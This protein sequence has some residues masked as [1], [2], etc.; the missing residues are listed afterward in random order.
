[1][2]SV[3]VKTLSKGL[4]I[5]LLAALVYIPGIGSVRLFDWDEINFAESAREMLVTGDWF[6]VQINFQSFWEKPPL[7]IWMQALSMK[8][9]GVGEFAARFPNAL[10]GILTL[11][12][13]FAIGSKLRD[14]RF[15]ILW[16]I[17]YGCS[18]LPAFYF[19]SG[20]IDP[21]FNLFI[22]SGI[23]FFFR[24]TEEPSAKWSAL[25]AAAIGLGI[26]TKG[27]VAFL[28][29]ALT[30]FFRLCFRK[31][32]FNFRWKDVFIFLAVMCFVGGFWFIALAFSG[33]GEVIRDFIDYQIRLFETKDA[34]HGG[35]LLYHFVWLFFGCIPASIMALPSF[36]PKTVKEE[37]D[38]HMAEM[39][40]WMMTAFWVVLILFTIVKTKIVHYS[41]FCYFPLSFLA[42][43][44]A[45]RIVSHKAEWHKWQSGL[46]IGIS[47][48][49]GI[50]L[51]VLTL[52]DALKGKLIPLIQDEF[53]VRCLEA[54]SDWIGFE[55]LIG[56]ALLIC[57]IWF[58]L[59]F[60]RYRHPLNF[61]FLAGGNLFFLFVSTVCAVGQVEKYTQ[62]SAVDF[63]IKHKGED[64]YILPTYYKS[65]A[66]YFYS[67]RQPEN[68][69]DDFDFL[70]T[71][72]LDK[73]CYFV[74]KMYDKDLEKFQ[75]DVPDARLIETKS[76]FAFYVREAA[77]Y[78]QDDA[79]DE[80]NQ[81]KIEK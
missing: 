74:V 21:W 75:S 49:F 8:I 19:K 28:I 38:P 79:C 6:N 81:E 16:A 39:F 40:K 70:R 4:I 34:G 13:L 24:Y 29:F 35:F 66:Q 80:C 23:Y 65:Y 56:V 15:G 76:G 60:R 31:F 48:I 72:E 63:F 69:C 55:P 25:S 67:D 26:M 43:Y 5:A 50:I 57:V 33:R 51:T 2:A 30:F 62:A 18:L 27:P 41:S 36:L 32:K 14:D 64:C 59:V 20:I 61:A 71:A 68:T 44:C 73:P 77:S 46:L 58:C 54:E 7:F 78:Q 22:F 37:S 12:L 11:T 53:A 3:Q 47:A 1:M 52:F 45:E 42:A 9:F 10:C 17:M